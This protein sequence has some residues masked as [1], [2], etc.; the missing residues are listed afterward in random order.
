MPSE[1]LKIDDVAGNDAVFGIR[2]CVLIAIA[3]GVKALTLKELCDGLAQIHAGSIYYHF[4]GG[5]L[6]PRFEQQEYNNDFAA[7]CRHELHD[8]QLAERLAVVDPTDYGDM[9]DLRR[10]LIEIIEQRVDESERLQ[11]VPVNRPF[12]FIQSK[13]IVFDTHTRVGEP[14]ALAELMPR[15]STGTVFYHFIDARRRSPA[16]LDDFSAWLCVFGDRY[17]RLIHDL[18]D[19]DPY[20]G[21]LVELRQQLADT[22]ARHA[23]ES[24][25]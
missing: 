15:F 22:F 20:F 2:D 14:E 24:A 3:T 12:E 4:W 11:W 10:E 21:T 1:S 18:A 7:W 13:I 9:E 16:R 23:E 8:A 17:T 25:P 5:L 6:Q 19:I